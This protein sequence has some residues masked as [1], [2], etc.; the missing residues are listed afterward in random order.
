MEATIWSEAL[1][2][3]RAAMGGSATMR[4][5]TRVN[6]EQASKRM[7]RKPILLNLGE[8]RWRMGKRATLAPI[9]FRR[10]IGA[11]TDGRGRRWQHGKPWRRWAH[12]NRDPA[13]GRPGRQGGGEACSTGEAG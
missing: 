10:G 2:C 1:W 6:V 4:A 11:G 8:G 9:R 7:M 5:G 3:Q 13:R 12:I